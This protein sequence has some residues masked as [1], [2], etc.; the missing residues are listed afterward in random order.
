MVGV[1]IALVVYRDDVHEDGVP[2]VWVETREAD[3]Q[4][5]EHPSEIGQRDVIITMYYIY[6][7]N[8]SN[9]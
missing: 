1:A 8:S 3:A 9:K 7:F 4:R 6:M 2:R 5:R